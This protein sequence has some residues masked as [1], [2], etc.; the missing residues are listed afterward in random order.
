MSKRIFNIQKGWFAWPRSRKYLNAKTKFSWP[1][2]VSK[3]DKLLRPKDIPEK[4]MVISVLKGKIRPETL[5]NGKE[6]F[7]PRSKKFRTVREGDTSRKS[8]KRLHRFRFSP[9]VC[10]GHNEVHLHPWKNRRLSVREA[11]RLQGIPDTYILPSDVSLTAKFSMVANGVP[12]PLAYNVAIKL[13]E[14]LK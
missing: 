7:Q 5:L 8:F 12:V 14:L 3:K 2:K 10:Y 9:T 1:G 13:Q 6:Y 4:L 11:M